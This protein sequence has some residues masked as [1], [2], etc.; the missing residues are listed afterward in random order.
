[1]KK[2]ILTPNEGSDPRS[3]CPEISQECSQE[4]SQD[5]TPQLRTGTHTEGV[6]SQE[7]N[8][9]QLFD[10][11]YYC[12][13]ELRARYLRTAEVARGGRASAA[14]KLK[15][16]DCVGWDY[17]EAKRCE[18]RQCALWLQNQKLFHPGQTKADER[19]AA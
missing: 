7:R 1:V 2:S 10:P 17:P 5:L 4:R 14:V 3:E 8:I 12:P 6:S 15:C 16:L 11:L 13:K 18:T 19:S 9:E